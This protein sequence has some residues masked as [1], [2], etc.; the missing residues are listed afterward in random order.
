MM[1]LSLLVKN[2]FNGEAFSM[3]QEK[4]YVDGFGR[5]LGMGKSR[6]FSRVFLWW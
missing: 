1:S 4:V 2:A 3:Y 5:E 6:L